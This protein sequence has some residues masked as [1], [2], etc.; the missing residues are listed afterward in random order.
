MLHAALPFAAVFPTKEAKIF[1]AERC[2]LKIKLSGPL[3]CWQQA[4]GIAVAWVMGKEKSVFPN[5]L[6]PH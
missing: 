5:V 4:V 3:V 2:F 6:L 1:K